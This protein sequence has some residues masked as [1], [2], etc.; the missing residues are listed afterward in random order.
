MLAMVDKTNDY[1]VASWTWQCKALQRKNSLFAYNN[2]KGHLV[3]WY[4]CSLVNALT[5]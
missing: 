1:G 4:M 2:T 3:N 5:L